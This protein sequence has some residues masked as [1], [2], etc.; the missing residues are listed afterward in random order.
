MKLLA[1]ETSCDE[2]GLAV[3]EVTEPET[4]PAFSI[5]GSKLASQIDLHAQYGG[6]F[7]MMA[8]REHVANFPILLT[9]LFK[10]L[11]IPDGA[12][13]VTG[14]QEQYITE[15]LAKEPDLAVSL[16]VYVRTHAKPDVDAIAV[17]VGPGL[18]PALWV[19][20]NAAKV[21]AML[22]EL[23]LVP[24]NHMEG[25]ILSVLF[26]G[27]HATGIQ[28]IADVAFPAL[29]LLVSG[30]HT[31]LVIVRDW[32]EYELIGQTRDDAAGEA[33]DKVARLLGLPYPG[34]PEI[35]KLASSVVPA[36][37][38]ILEIKLPRPMMYTSDYDFSFSG[39]KTA[40]RYL[41]DD[42]KKE[43]DE[44][45]TETK[46]SI[47]YEFETAAID[48]LVHKTTK[49]IRE[50]GIQTLI[51]GGG[52]SANRALRNRFNTTL[53]GIL[54]TENILFPRGELSTDNAIM[55]GIAGYFRY[56]KGD[57]PDSKTLRAIG[58]L[59]L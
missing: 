38:G 21:L 18:E 35:S 7:P 52:V 14:E 53:A 4:N 13:E 36:Q 47:A 30:G 31:E 51:V 6:V 48:V 54:P 43:S 11:N 15:L 58:S 55:I 45:S 12:V 25:H 10:D 19:G 24:V 37:A 2:T 5:V 8:K 9:E 27:D 17:T 16:L 50:F 28:P 23:P 42:L 1:I 49:A 32:M 34:G 26:Q 41:V 39:L 46:A 22:W 40:V 44:I 29:A 59:E 20:I 56:Q 3:L 57:L 33:F